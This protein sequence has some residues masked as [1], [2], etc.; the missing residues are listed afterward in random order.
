MGHYFASLFY[1]LDIHHWFLGGFMVPPAVPVKHRRA[2]VQIPAKWHLV[3]PLALRQNNGEGK[4]FSVSALL[5]LP[6]SVCHSRPP[7]LCWRNA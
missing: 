3:R 1:V 2:V 5:P 7:L 4:I 6:A